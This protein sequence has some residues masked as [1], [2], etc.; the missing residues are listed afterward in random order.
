M[1]H[2]CKHKKS[3]KGIPTNVSMLWR[4][5]ILIGLTG[6]VLIICV[7]LHKE[8]IKENQ[9]ELEA[10]GIEEQPS[11]EQSAEKSLQTVS[12]V[13]EIRAETEVETE[14]QQNE[15]KAPISSYPNRSSGNVLTREG[16][17]CYYGQHKETYY[18]ERILPGRKLK[19]PGRYTDNLG[20]VRDKDGYI[21]VAADYSY[22]PYGSVVRTS[23]GLGKVYDTGCPYGIIDI[24]TNW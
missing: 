24:Y 11:T 15:T 20:L 14:T 16:G 23:L 9:F 5:I 13:E 21:C 19:I 17:V 1:L 7:C 12:A 8:T 4:S 2:G 6:I 10:A 18:S 3:Q 22:L